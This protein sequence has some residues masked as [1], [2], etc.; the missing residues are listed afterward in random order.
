[1]VRRGEID[2]QKSTEV[3]RRPMIRKKGEDLKQRGVSL[4][5]V[6]SL[7]SRISKGKNS[8]GEKGEKHG[9]RGNFA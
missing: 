9:K 7:S 3:V 1:L 8:M 5:A 2:H 6:L 4:S